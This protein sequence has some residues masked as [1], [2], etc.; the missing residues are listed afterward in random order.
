MVSPHQV[1]TPR[2][3]PWKAPAALAHAK[4]TLTTTLTAS[5][6]KTR[7][8]WRVSFRQLGKHH[9]ALTDVHYGKPG[10]F[11]SILVRLCGPCASGQHGTRAVNTG[12][13]SGHDGW[14]RLGDRHHGQISKRRH[15]WPGPHAVTGW[16]DGDGTVLT[17]QMS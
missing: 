4:G 16:D 7:L 3:K 1:V 15:P 13:G 10:Q 8:S 12:N 14:D 2:N 5:G 6:K 17:R 11:G 9:V